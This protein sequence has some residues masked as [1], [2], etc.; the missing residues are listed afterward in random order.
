[1]FKYQGTRCSELR[2]QCCRKRYI[3]P[4]I[5]LAMFFFAVVRLLFFCYLQWGMNNYYCSCCLKIISTCSYIVLLWSSVILN[6]IILHKKHYLW[7]RVFMYFLAHLLISF[8]KKISLVV[9]FCVNKFLLAKVV[10]CRGNSLISGHSI[11]FY[12][13]SWNYIGCEI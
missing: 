5:I 1:M 12:K 13:L 6:F 2:L 4:T 8:H 9:S 11:R 7:K 3:F 10:T